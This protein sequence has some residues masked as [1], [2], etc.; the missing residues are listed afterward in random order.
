MNLQYSYCGSMCMVYF[1][2]CTSDAEIVEM[3]WGVDIEPVLAMVSF[4]FG[5]INFYN[6][7]SPLVT[8][9]L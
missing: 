7:F 3:A 6:F 9:K 4:T 5:I 2:F 8:T 1:I